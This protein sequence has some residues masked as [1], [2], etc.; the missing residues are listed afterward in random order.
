MHSGTWPRTELSLKWVKETVDEQNF[1]AS[2]HDGSLGVCHQLMLM[3]GAKKRTPAPAGGHLFNVNTPNSAAWVNRRAG[4]LK[5]CRQGTA[6]Y[7]LSMVA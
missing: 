5:E 1:L 6:Q 2:G 4:E 7:S 3:P